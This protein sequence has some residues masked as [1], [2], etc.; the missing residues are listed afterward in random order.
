MAGFED[1]LETDLRLAGTLARIH[2]AAFAGLGRAWSGPEILALMNE[3]IVAVRLAHHEGA[4]GALIPVGF[5]LYRATAG[6]A[7]L[8]TVAVA[9][10]AQRAGLG[11]ELI[12]ACI[13]GAAS[14]GA[15]RLFLEVGAGN[16]AALALYGKA[17]FR[18]CGRRKGYYQRPGGSREDAIVM[19]RPLTLA[20][21]RLGE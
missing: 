8:L 14:G 1:R 17:G 11:R 7:E 12:E 13:A 2:A 9:P 4:D 10:D 19:E 3:P 5:A 6:E 15:E 21:D 18:E 20:V 16:A